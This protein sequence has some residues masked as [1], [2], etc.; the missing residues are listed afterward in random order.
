MPLQ[1]LALA[2]AE[3]AA[4]V[5]IGEASALGTLGR[6][7]MAE[8]QVTAGTGF[9]ETTLMERLAGNIVAKRGAD[10]LLCLSIPA[11][12]IGIAI[13][14][15]SGSASACAVAAVW[16]LQNLGLLPAPNLEHLLDLSTQAIYT[17]SGALAGRLLPM[18]PPMEA[19]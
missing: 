16:I 5:Q 4:S 9:F 3:M 10:G 12:R 8:P 18:M 19:R 6:A 1:N 14:A 2:Y 11:E 13:K 15:E 17:W 7:M